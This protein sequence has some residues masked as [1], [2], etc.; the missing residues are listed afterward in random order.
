MSKEI[1]ELLG[2]ARKIYVRKIKMFL[3]ANKDFGLKRI[4]PSSLPASTL[5]K[6]LLTFF[7][8]KLFVNLKV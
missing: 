7:I 8:I 6:L 1:S 2:S 3:L 4:E 5:L